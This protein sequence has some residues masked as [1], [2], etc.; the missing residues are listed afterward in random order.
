MSYVAVKGGEQAILNAETLLHYYRMGKQTSSLSVDQIVEQL[1][2]AVDRVMSEGSLYA[3]DLA[4]LAL[5]Q[6]AG[7]TLEAAFLLRAH[8]ASVSR[9][10]VSR[11]V[12]T[13]RMRV[14]RRI[15][16]A[17]KDIP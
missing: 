15:S 7:D 14:M 13:D 16:A 5:K 2:L 8:R 12:R 6:A 17:F 10:G 3:A 4:G 9:I 1:P 11:P